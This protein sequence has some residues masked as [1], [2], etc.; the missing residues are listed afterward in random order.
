MIDLVCWL[1]NKKPKEVYSLGSKGNTSFND[2]FL[3]E[4]ILVSAHTRNT[5]LE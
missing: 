1:L 4:S 5:G 3:R 2:K